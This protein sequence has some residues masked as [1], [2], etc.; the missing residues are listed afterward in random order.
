MP[1]ADFRIAHTS[2]A[3]RSTDNLQRTLAA[4][5]RKQ[6]EVSSLKR[7][8]RPSDSPVDAVSALRLR[9]DMGRNEQI[10]RNIDDAMGWLGVADNA[11][12]AVVEQLNRV[13]DLAV[14]A[15]NA[16][17][18]ATARE[19]IASEVEK[20]RETL[21][22]LANTEYNGRAI[23]AGTASTDAAYDAS[24]AYQGVS[25]TIERTVAPGVRVQINVNGD[26]VFGATGNDLFLAVNQIA[27]AVRSDPSQL[28]TLVADLDTRTETVKTRLAEVGTR[29]RRVETMKD[30]NTA[31][32][33][34]MRQNLSNVE[35]TDL[36]QA[37][38]EL[39]LQEVAY[40]AALQATARAIQPS[41]VDFLR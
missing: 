12:T 36:A 28:D 3:R 15:R 7:L 14:Q 23:F 20:I 13:R 41:L 38:M 24:G 8:R 29:F 6:E 33:L 31:D 22:G 27:N 19:G 9:S 32:S 18:D 25:R 35:D 17:A 2:I 16:S 39:Q 5:S 11:L 37:V 21:L 1:S 34:T 26:E 4:L 30:R 40:Q 10:S